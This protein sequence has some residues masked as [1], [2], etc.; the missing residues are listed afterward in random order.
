MICAS[1]TY[2]VTSEFGPVIRSDGL[3]AVL[4]S[5]YASLLIQ[6]PETTKY[7]R[8]NIVL[9]IR[10]IIRIPFFIT[11]F[12]FADW[13]LLM[14]QGISHAVKIGIFRF[15]RFMLEVWKTTSKNRNDG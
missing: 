1:S 4:F 10:N 9:N 2:L 3:Y 11:T 6:K 13:R 7:F 8:L 5:F 14:K 15:I 12:A